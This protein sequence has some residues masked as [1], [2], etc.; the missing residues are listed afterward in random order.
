MRALRTWISHTGGIALLEFALVLPFIMLMLLGG[1][2]VTRA[3]VITQRTE[4]TGYVVA[5]VTSQYMPYST[6]AA[7]E[8]SATELTTNVFPLF[9]R[10]M[11]SYADTTKQAVILTSVRQ[12][13]GVKLV[14]W[15]VA[16]GGTLT[17][18]VTSIVNGLGPAA[19][20]PSVANTAASFTGDAATQLA[21][22]VD[23]ENVIV[24][25]VFYYYQPIWASV[26][27]A[28]TVN[29]NGT[30]TAA[31]IATP[32]VLIKRMFFRPRNGDLICLPSSFMYSSCTTTT[33]TG[34][35]TTTGSSCAAPNCSQPGLSGVSNCC[36]ANGTSWSHTGGCLLNTC[37]NGVIVKDELHNQAWHDGTCD[38]SGTLSTSASSL[39][40]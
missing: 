27:N 4:K 15:Q 19:I 7:G 28:T 14:K 38:E 24:A 16:G 37:T 3:I 20:G 11:G 39:C 30:Q 17:N 40:M 32:R 12:E 2:E 25:E 13:G 36:V 22:M 6:G 18:G 23:N 31:S 33:G 35:T 9:S 26:L 8:I 21:G 10:I 5:D 1:L 34:T 29:Y